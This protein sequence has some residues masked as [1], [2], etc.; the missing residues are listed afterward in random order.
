MVQF[1]N[2]TAHSLHLT[3]E[4]A[5]LDGTISKPKERKEKTLGRELSQLPFLPSLNEFQAST[6]MKFPERSCIL[7][8]DDEIMLNLV[9]MFSNRKYKK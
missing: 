2:H 4:Q 6:A 5:S 9:R 7:L 8:E 1:L 3:K